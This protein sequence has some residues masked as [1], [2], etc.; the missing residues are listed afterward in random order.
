MEVVAGSPEMLLTKVKS[1]TVKF[2]RL[3]KEVG[4]PRR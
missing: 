4:I 2:T 3:I 1:E